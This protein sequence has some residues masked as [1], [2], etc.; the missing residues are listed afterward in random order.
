MPSKYYPASPMTAAQAL[1]EHAPLE[2]LADPALGPRH[3]AMNWLGHSPRTSAVRTVAMRS[4]RLTYRTPWFVLPHRLDL[5]VLLNRR[6]LVGCGAEVGVKQGE[7]S[8]LLLQHWNGRHLISID[9]WLAAPKSDYLD[10]AN[11]SQEEH[12]AYH[13]QTVKRL[14]RFGDRTSV[15]R[16]TGDEAAERIPHHSL[17]FVYLDAR[18]DFPSVTQDLS[19]WVDKVRPGGILAGHDY[20]DGSFPGGEFDV[21]SAVDEFFAG[22]PVRVRAT[23]ADPPWISWYARVR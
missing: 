17:D 22:S 10:V 7:Y 2:Q 11:V 19:H 13:A 14:A 15:W 8:E 12:D 9:P 6:G 21:R 1:P 18:H 16:M 23:F 4:V 20:L 3:R 5:P